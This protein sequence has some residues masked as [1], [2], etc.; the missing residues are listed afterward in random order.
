MTIHEFGKE[1]KEII[2]L[3]HPSV[4]RWDYFERVIPLLERDYHLIVPALPGYDEEEKSDFTSVE[5]ITWELNLWLKEEGLTE[6]YAVYGCSMGGS[7]A[8]MAMLRQQIPIRHCIMDGGITPYELPWIVTRFIALKD[9]LMM[10]IGRAGG[11]K[12]LRKAFATD[13]Y[14]E[15]D[16]QYVAD[17]LKS[18]S[19]KTLWRTFDSCNNYKIPSPIPPLNTKIHYWYADGEEKE[20]KADIAYMKRVFDQIEFKVLPKLGHGGLVLLK[21]EMFAAMIHELR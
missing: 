11:M 17:V 2:V 16:L 20:R 13:E 19:S 15:E 7:V 5:Q 6:V 10:M 9:Y 8:L 18:S 21:P 14:S 3:I 12:L 4:V 1:N